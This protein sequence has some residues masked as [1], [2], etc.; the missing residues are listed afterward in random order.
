MTAAHD[1]HGTDAPARPARRSI[2]VTARRADPDRATA[3]RFTPDP[4]Y[5]AM[6]HVAG[7]RLVWD[8]TRLHL[9]GPDGTRARVE[10]PAGRVTVTIGEGVV[11]HLHP[12][13]PAAGGR[14][15]SAPGTSRAVVLDRSAERFVRFACALRGAH[16]GAVTIDDR[17]SPSPRTPRLRTASRGSEHR[18]G[19]FARRVWHVHAPSTSGSDADG[20]ADLVERLERLAAL[21]RAGDLTDAEYARAKARLLG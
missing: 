20:G 7:G 3:R 16:P 1:E 4:R 21:H 8:G 6:F 2:G 15:A 17:T 13:R 18:P 12:A 11:V 5:P 9:L 10:L 14:A 19:V